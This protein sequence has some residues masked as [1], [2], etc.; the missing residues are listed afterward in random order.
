MAE[1]RV[2][3]LG[4]MLGELKPEGPKG[5]SLLEASPEPPADVE[6]MLSALQPISPIRPDIGP[7]L[8]TPFKEFSG[9]TTLPQFSAISPTADMSLD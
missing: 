7:Q 6:R 2:V 5:P 9:V 3:G 8:I 4:P 1:E